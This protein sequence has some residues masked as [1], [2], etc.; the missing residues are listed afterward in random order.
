MTERKPRGTSFTSWID[1][2]INEATERLA[3]TVGDLVPYR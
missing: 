1:Q 3:E 2:Q